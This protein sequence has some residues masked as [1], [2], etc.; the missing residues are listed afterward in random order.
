MIF[1]L[2]LAGARAGNYFVNVSLFFL[3]FFFHLWLSSWLR[4]SRVQPDPEANNSTPTQMSAL[5]YSSFYFLQLDLPPA[6]AAGRPP[7]LPPVPPLPKCIQP[8]RQQ[9]LRFVFVFF[10]K[11]SFNRGKWRGW[12]S[13]GAFGEAADGMSSPPH[14]VKPIYSAAC[15]RGRHG[16]T[17]VSPHAES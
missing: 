16:R 9:I 5:I 10:S 11:K 6:T 13:G 15:Q 2:T 7:P 3:I 8:W 1:R 12:R 14:S 4:D 17:S